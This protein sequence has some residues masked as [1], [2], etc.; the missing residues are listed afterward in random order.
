[1][2]TATSTLKWSGQFSISTSSKSS[3]LNGDKIVL[4][5]SALE[6]LLA[7]APIVSLPEGHGRAITSNFDPFNP[8]SYAAELAARENFADRQHQL[9]HPLTFRIVNPENGRVVYAGIREFS[10]EEGEVLLS[11]FLKMT[12]GLAEMQQDLT[13]VG[14]QGG[15]VDMADVREESSDMPKV[16]IHVK[17]VPKGTYVR[18]RPLEAGYDAEDWKSLLERYLRDNFTTLTRDEILSVRSGP[19]ETFRFLVDKFTPEGDAVCIIDTDLEVDIEALNEEQA[20]ETLKQKLEKSQHAPGSEQ[21]SS[22]GGSLSQRQEFHGRVL[23]GEYVDFE[24]QEWPQDHRLDL[25][26][27]ILQDDAELDLFASPFSAYQRSKP[28]EDEHVFGNFDSIPS[29][30][31]KISHS[32][33]ELENAEKIYVSVHGWSDPKSNQGKSPTPVAPIPFS[34]R[35]NSEPTPSQEQTTGEEI[36]SAEDVICKN[37]QQAVPK[38][39][40]PLHEAFCYRN[41]VLCPECKQVFQKR[42]EN[43]QNHWHCPYDTSHGNTAFSRRKHDLVYHPNSPYFCPS[44]EDQSSNFPTLPSLAQHRTHS[45][46]SKLI[47]CQFCHLLVP[48]RGSEDP[49]FEDPEVLLSGLTPHELNDGARTTECHVCNRIIRLRDMKT[50][51]RHHDLDRLSRALP[52]VC[53]NPQCGHSIPDREKEI[54]EREH[55][56]LCGTCFGPLYVT[57]YDPEGKAL[58]RRIERKLL[59]QLTGGCGKPW[60]RGFCRTARKNSS[61]NDTPLSAKDALPMIQPI[62]EKLNAGKEVGIPFCVDEGSQKRRVAAE[63]LS[64]EGQGGYALEWWIR[65][66][67]E[68]HGDVDS[69]RTWLEARAPKIGETK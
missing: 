35:V 3:K 69:A 27:E 68:N 13:K 57:N 23:P 34:I 63:V 7:A 9:P 46:P 36:P 42:S 14:V 62:M 18:L 33:V 47:L 64:A 60:C 28:R 20:R 37:C 22:V 5:P 21:G 1:M 40:L 41:N 59:Q 16:T 30:R 54:T 31:I 43:W 11:P 55:F 8:Y 19:S 48:Q 24:L 25:S 4:P 65:A 39:T 6:A 49:A 2:D 15:D 45:C 44:C 17:E 58:R 56:G 32:N 61:G 38:R 51:L 66:L 29:K 53:I 52:Q 12:L 10:A 67:E 50:H 26:L